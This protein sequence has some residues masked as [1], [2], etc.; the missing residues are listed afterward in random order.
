MEQIEVARTIPAPLAAVFARYTDHA[1]WSSWAGLG[2]VKLGREG[3]P[4]RDGTG[5]VRVIGLGPFAVHEEVLA[6]EAPHRMTYRVV[7]GLVP[8]R[9]HGGEVTFAAVPEG[10]RIVWRCHFESTLP[11]AGPATAWVTRQVFARVL[12]K[13]A[14]LTFPAD[15]AP[16]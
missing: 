2:P 9:D 16:A 14:T 13:L 1:G 5:C 8:M 15:R 12:R 3:H 10:T 11:G 4:E 7:K 6:F